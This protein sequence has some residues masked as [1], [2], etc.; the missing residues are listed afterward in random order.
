MPSAWTSAEPATTAA[1]APVVSRRNHS[2]PINQGATSAYAHAPMTPTT[3]P[4][5]NRL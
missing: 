1:A 4:I 5:S 2:G 3:A